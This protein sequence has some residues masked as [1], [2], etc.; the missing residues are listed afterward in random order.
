VHLCHNLSSLRV[1]GLG[2]KFEDLQSQGSEIHVQIRISSLQ[3]GPR[4]QM[5]ETWLPTSGPKYR[6][7]DQSSKL[8][9]QLKVMISNLIGIMHQPKHPQGNQMTT[10]MH[11]AK[12]HPQRQRARRGPHRRQCTLQPRPEEGR[13]AEDLGPLHRPPEARPRVGRFL[14]HGVAE[15]D[16][17]DQGCR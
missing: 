15:H 17:V 14:L 7:R 4:G 12:A 8:G 5:L 2:P 3:S 10:Q 11:I 9:R 1:L 13:V 16:G 6:F